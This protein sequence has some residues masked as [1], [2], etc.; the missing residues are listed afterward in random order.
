MLKMSTP[1]FLL[2]ILVTLGVGVGIHAYT[3]PNRQSEIVVAPQATP[4]APQPERSRAEVDPEIRIVRDGDRWWVGSM[5]LSYD[6]DGVYPKGYSL[7]IQDGNPRSIAT[8]EDQ[9]AMR[10]LAEI[11]ACYYAFG[12]AD[13]LAT[14]SAKFE[15]RLTGLRVSVSEVPGK[16]F[17]VAP[18]PADAINLAR[19]AQ[20]YWAPSHT[21]KLKQ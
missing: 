8:S 12:T 16:D 2:I 17:I 9:K 15:S 10:Q 11:E 6:V 5:A 13:K 14:Y 20:W 4:A 3:N 1:C 19:H 21:T 18:A 7:I